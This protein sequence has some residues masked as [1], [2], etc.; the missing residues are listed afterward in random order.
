[1]G[2]GPA[3]TSF[4]FQSQTVIVSGMQA[5]EAKDEGATSLQYVVDKEQVVERLSDL[6]QKQDLSKYVL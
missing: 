1:M 2:E 3:H 4:L 5:R 6:L